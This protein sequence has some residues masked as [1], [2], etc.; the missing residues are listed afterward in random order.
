MTDSPRVVEPFERVPPLKRRQPGSDPD[1]NT[2]GHTLDDLRRLAVQAQHPRNRERL[3]ALYKTASQQTNATNWAAHIGYAKKTVLSWV[4]CY[5]GM[6]QTQG[7]A[8][9]VADRVKPWV[10]AASRASDTV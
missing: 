3:L 8:N 10:E 9:A 1:L 5:R 6:Y 2:W 4:H 7:P